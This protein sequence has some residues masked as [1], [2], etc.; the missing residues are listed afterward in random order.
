MARY[1]RSSNRSI[2]SA[3]H[4]ISPAH[5]EAGLVRRRVDPDTVAEPSQ[6]RRRDTG[7]RDGR[8]RR[9]RHGRC[10]HRPCVRVARVTAA[11]VSADLVIVRHCWRRRRYPTKLVAPAPSVAISVKSTPLPERSRR[12]PVSS[13]ELSV[14][15]IVTLLYAVADADRPEG[16][17]RCRRS[18]RGGRI[19]ARPTQRGKRR[20]RVVHRARVVRRVGRIALVVDACRIA[21]VIGIRIREP[22]HAGRTGAGISHDGAEAGAVTDAATE[23]VRVGVSTRARRAG[24][25]VLVA[26]VVA[27][28]VRERVLAEAARLDDIEGVRGE[29]A[30]LT[31]VMTPAMPQASESCAIS[32]TTSAP[33]WSRRLCTDPSCRRSYPGDR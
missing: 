27:D 23:P 19:A 22:R 13:L 18:D 29:R 2:V 9:R 31:V 11:V 33:T 17:R 10:R 14:Q 21:V 30:V 7:R 1:R 25:V 24:T 12:N 6:R 26:L 4:P 8:W 15:R 28:L 3:L 20:R 32:D 16:A 5:F